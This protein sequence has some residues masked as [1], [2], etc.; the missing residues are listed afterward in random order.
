M[1]VALRLLGHLVDLFLEVGHLGFAD[2]FLELALKFG[3]HAAQL[4]HPL[5]DRAQHSRQF[6]RPDRD[7][8]DDADD[9]KLAPPDVK[10]GDVN[11]AGCA[12]PTGAAAPLALARGAAGDQPALRGSVCGCAEA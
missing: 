7:Q 11:S 12:H 3:R 4:R 1:G 10:H 8:R 5:P 9:E 6:L 2:G